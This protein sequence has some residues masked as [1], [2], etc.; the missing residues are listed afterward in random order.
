[1]LVIALA[2]CAP[3]ARMEQPA[4]PGFIRMEA[5]KTAGQ[6]FMARFDGLAGVSVYLKPDLGGAGNLVAHLHDSPQDPATLGT[7]QIALAEVTY[8]GYYR[9]EFPAIK[10]SFNKDYYLEIELEGP[11]SVRLGYANEFAYLNGAFYQNGL[12]GDSQAAFQ[13]LYDPAF[14]LLGLANEGGKWFG[15]L[16]QAALL[17]VVPGWGLLSLLAA[18]NKRHW[19]E[20]LGLSAGVSLALYPVLFL[21]SGVVGLRPGVYFV[22]L[23]PLAGLAI[24]FYGKIS[25]LATTRRFSR[26]ENAFI[27]RA[28]LFSFPKFSLPDLLL[29]VLIALI[30]AVRLWVIRNMDVPLWGD[31]YQHAVITQLLVDHGGLFHSWEPYAPYETFT[32]HYGFSAIA[33]LFVWFSGLAA[34]AATLLTGQVLNGLAVLAL[35][36]L[37]MRISR[38]NLWAGIGTVLFAGLLSPQPAFFVNWGRYAQLSGQVILPVALCLL[39]DAL[40]GGLEP[41][42]GPGSNSQRTWLFSRN[43]LLQISF[44]GLAFAGL[45]LHYYR[46]PIFYATFVLAWLIGWGIPHWRFR[47]ANWIPVVIKGLVIA[48]FGLL[49]F[50]PWATRLMNGNLASAVGAGVASA[51]PLAE[52]VSDFEV[53]REITLFS[54][55][56]LLVFALGGFAASLIRRRWMVAALV[57]WYLGL[58]AYMA[59]KILRLPGANMIQSFAI[60]LGLYIPLS[61]LAGWLIGQFAGLFIDSSHQGEGDSTKFMHGGVTG[62]QKPAGRSYQKAGPLAERA[63]AIFLLFLACWG[64]IRQRDILKPGSFSLATRPDV[65]AMDWIR[66]NTD[67]QSRFLVEGYRIYGGSSIVGS[68]A[69]WWIPLLAGRP[70]TI[71][72]QYA[73]LNEVPDAADYTKNAVA[74]VAALEK[75]SPG[76]PEGLQWLCRENIAYAYIGQGQG[77]VG[78]GASQLFSPEELAQS[79][80]FQQIYHQD[81]VYIF[82]F[83]RRVCGGLQ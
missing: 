35:F 73:I 41:S 46:M 14:L 21:W 31:S 10:R 19:A 74:L 33:A 38:G 66:A 11:G 53:W 82:K 68:D 80:A 75:V 20:K 55:P 48:G 6:S 70:N 12:P 49:L 50:L 57:L 17:L 28:Q 76:S 24:L 63:L 71:P 4:H 29:I 64:A 59:G 5:G 8:P 65:Q 13:L 51:A 77:K 9:F 39:W 62:L 79:P 7:A 32:V 42:A 37:A 69:G 83:D 58:V 26:K 18:W 52:L 22:W 30:F 34:P 45:A 36:P 61:L 72:P 56:I 1:M 44:A 47:L 40:S 54:S 16:L 2:G 81:R 25:S 67:S 23:P 60:L 78:Y 15:W 27:H 43:S 3:V